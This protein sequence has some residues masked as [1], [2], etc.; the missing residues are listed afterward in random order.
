M[1]VERDSAD[2]S[3]RYPPTQAEAQIAG[4][5][6]LAGNRCRW[7]RIGIDLQPPASM[8]GA[9]ECHYEGVRFLRDSSLVSRLSK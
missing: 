3:G 4:V 2:A 7:K 5:W 9:D 1:A 6:S 8:G